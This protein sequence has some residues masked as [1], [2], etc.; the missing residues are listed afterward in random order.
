MKKAFVIFSFVCLAVAC[1]N[2]ATTD[3]GP[4]ETGQA[5][6]PADPQADQGLALIAK[7][8]CLGCHKVAEPNIGPAYQAVA[9]RYENNA[10][11]ID[12]LAH[13]IIN[14]G[15]GNWGS[16]PMK[17]HSEISPDDAKLM[18]KYVMSL[19]K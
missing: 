13:K 12:S 3:K 2:N 15:A 8:D 5:E 17:S 10:G 6:K 14:G 19:K 11:T 7:S 9:D 4:A 16:I 18:A 1:G